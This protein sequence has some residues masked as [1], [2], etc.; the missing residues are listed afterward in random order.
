LWVAFLLVAEA[1]K[2]ATEQAQ[3]Y[4]ENEHHRGI[5]S[6]TNMRLGSYFKN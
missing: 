6:D 4:G 5:T 2:I 3:R 1:G